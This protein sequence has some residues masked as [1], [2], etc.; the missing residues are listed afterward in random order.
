MLK[1]IRVWSGVSKH[2]SATALLA[3]GAYLL[4]LLWAS[5]LWTRAFA[6]VGRACAGDA[7]RSLTDAGTESLH[8][9]TNVLH[10][11]TESLHVW[12]DMLPPRPPTLDLELSRSACGLTCSTSGSMGSARGRTRSTC[13]PSAPLP[14]GPSKIRNGLA[15]GVDRLAPDEDRPSETAAKGG[16]NPL[17]SGAGIPESAAGEEEIAS[18]PGEPASEPEVFPDV[19]KLSR[20]VVMPFNLADAI[21]GEVGLAHN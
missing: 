8:I 11:R 19:G 17:A 21:Y 12:T 20:K 15:L 14:E 9:R 10:A 5:Y 3:A 1:E 4:C 6:G 18:N 7:R 16:S 13:G 2:A